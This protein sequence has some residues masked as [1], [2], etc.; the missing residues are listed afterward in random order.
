MKQQKNKQL[1]SAYVEYL[2]T[3]SLFSLRALGREVG[4]AISTKKKKEDLV[5]EISAVLCGEATSVPRSKY[6][7]P[8]KNDYVDPKIYKKLEDIRAE[9][10]T[11]PR[12]KEVITAESYSDLKNERT[13]VVVNA[14]D[15]TEEPESGYDKTVY[16]GM[17]ERFDEDYVLLNL[18]GRE[19]EP[20]VWIPERRLASFK[21]RIGDVVSCYA[22]DLEDKLVASCILT[23][24]GCYELPSNRPSFE[25]AE[26]AY[27]SEK[28]CFSDK[29]TENAAVKYIDWLLPVVYG[30]RGLIRLAPAERTHELLFDMISGA[31]RL[32]SSLSVYGLLV[33]GAPETAK[34]FRRTLWT[35]RLVVT[36][37]DDDAE[38][39]VF[40]A[41]SILKRAERQAEMGTNVLL[42][43]DSLS[44]LANVYDETLKNGEGKALPCGLNS[45]SVRFVKKFLGSGRALAS[46]GSLTVIGVMEADADDYLVQALSK[47][48][49]WSFTFDDELSQKR[50]AVPAD[51]SLTD[52]SRREE[53]CEPKLLKAAKELLQVKKGS[54]KLSSLVQKAKN[55]EALQTAIETA[56]KK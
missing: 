26:V 31:R 5:G 48:A 44:A 2:S 16:V 28:I 45:K 55:P 11:Q 43:V 37:Y 52:C 7:A 47:V 27:S 3:Q 24:N 12:P 13:E 20:I 38:L 53:L 10:S 14:K 56:L 40:A 18:N 35:D 6:G 33:D 8:V 15:K 30:Q 19:R 51:F 49:N 22:D 23:I 1:K 21:A 46:G 42:F 50:V 34:E 17:L 25:T 39:Q 4:V 36:T 41:E 32:N 54:E 29:K 9:Y